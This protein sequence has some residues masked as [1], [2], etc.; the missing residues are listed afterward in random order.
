M[1]A[2]ICKKCGSI[3]DYRTSNSG[4]H[5]RADCRQCGA[6][7]KFLG[8]GGPAVCY[9]EKYKGWLISAIT[10]IAWLKWLLGNV[11]IKPGMRVH[12]QDQLDKLQG[13]L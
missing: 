7:I 3:D 12:Y 10:D 6:Y 4:D 8:K 2:L 13:L 1:E 9:Y 11:P 5:I